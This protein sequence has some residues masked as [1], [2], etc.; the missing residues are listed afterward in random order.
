MWCQT[1]KFLLWKGSIFFLW[2]GVYSVLYLIL[3]IPAIS[4]WLCLIIDNKKDAHNS[5]EIINILLACRMYSQ[6]I[7]SQWHK[8]PPPNPPPP[9][10][11]S[12]LAQ[13]PSQ[14]LP[15][16]CWQKERAKMMEEQVTVDNPFMDNKKCMSHFADCVSCYTRIRN[17]S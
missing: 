17:P 3:N 1:D 8:H 16:S 15:H 12:P 7:H 10:S 13:G 5:K 4:S 2:R 6:L 11:H 14:R 9:V